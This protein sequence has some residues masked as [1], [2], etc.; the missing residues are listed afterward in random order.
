MRDLPRDEDVAGLFAAAAK[1]GTADR[2]DGRYGSGIDWNEFH[3]P[4]E[5]R[6]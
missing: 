3:M 6:R 5:F 4:T 1:R 2:R